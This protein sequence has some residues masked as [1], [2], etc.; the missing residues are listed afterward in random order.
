MTLSLLVVALNVNWEPFIPL[1]REHDT[2][3]C[4]RPPTLPSCPTPNTFVPSARP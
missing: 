1:E 3:S 4:E 2:V